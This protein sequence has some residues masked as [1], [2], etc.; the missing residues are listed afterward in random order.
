MFSPCYVKKGTHRTKQ[1]RR[2]WRNL[3]VRCSEA[4][5][6][7]LFSFDCKKKSE[8]KKISF[9]TQTFIGTKRDIAYNSGIKNCYFTS[10]HRKKFCLALA[11]RYARDKRL[12]QNHFLLRSQGAR[13]SIILIA[14][15][16]FTVVQFFPGMRGRFLSAS[17]SI[18]RNVHLASAQLRSPVPC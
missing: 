18:R 12:E 3:F 7:I 17:G 13:I 5:V 9:V 4:I 11:A 6:I 16:L 14:E 8:E 2:Y 10:R 15:I 1:R